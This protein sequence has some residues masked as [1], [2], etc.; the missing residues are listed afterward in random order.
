MNNIDATGHVTGRSV[1][2]DDIPERKGTLY[3]LAVGADIAHG[4]IGH[5][6]MT[7]AESHP[8]I[9]SIL[10]SKDI[11]GENQVGGI[12]P[13]E[14]LFAENEVHF[15][16]QP[17]ALIV[18]ENELS[19]RKARK[20]IKIQYNELPPITDPRTA[21]E[22]GLFLVPPRTF[23]SGDVDSAWSDCA[24][25]FEGTAESGSQEHLY[26]ET[27]G[28]Y[29]YPLEN[30]NLKIH[31]STQGPAIVQKT[32]ANVLGRSMHHIEVDVTR[33]GGAF[34]GKEDQATVWACMTA[35][36]AQL[37][38]RPIK[39]SLQRVDDMRMTG[40]R[41]PY[42]SDF[43]I[44]LSEE[45]K[46]LAFEASYFQNGGAAADLSPAIM[47]RTLF[48]VT[49]S[50]YIPN[51]KATAYSCRTNLPPFTAFRGFG[52]PQAMFVMESAIA[53]AA[54]RLKIPALEIQSRNLIAE[55]DSFHYGQVAV[56]PRA[57]ESWEKLHN[58]HKLEKLANDISEFNASNQLFKKG[59]ALMP[60][61]FGISFTKTPMN[62]ARALVHIYQD[63]SAGISTGAVEMGQGV[64]TKLVQVAAKTLS[65][66]PSRVRIESTNTTRVANTSPTAASSGADLNG[67][68]LALACNELMNRLRRVAAKEL[69]IHEEKL[70]IEFEKVLNS[71]KPTVISWD[72]LIEH[73]VLSR[74]NLTAVGHYATPLIHFDKTTG[75]GHPF[76]YHVFGLAAVVAKVD[77]LRGR[78]EIEQVEVVHDFGN[79]LNLKVDLGQLEGGIV[80]GIGWVTMEEVSFDDKGQLLANSLSTYKVPDIYAAPKHINCT[81]LGS[82]GP[83]LAIMKSKAIGEPPFMYGIGAWFALRN[84]I[85]AFNPKSQIPFVSPMTPEQVL[86][87]L[88]PQKK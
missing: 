62:Q 38:Q 67:K 25:I 61:C 59:M 17:I 56:S 24:Y 14:P 35:L 60:V 55:K 30:G 81:P 41:H 76:A 20:L 69:K 22:L 37:L 50:Y 86:L 2:L 11:P 71:G 45:L 70:K 16:G 87:S 49:N 19:A 33:L 80:Q 32:A 15:H 51:V 1:Y 4:E 23:S 13:D 72:K 18:A 65:I 3:A 39:M 42:S 83:D 28:A 63:G 12:V 34:G 9:V 58:D 57:R 82:E 53:L 6:D 40:K 73:A 31:S 54:E 43:K 5:I 52:A 64:N 79:S 48:H 74:V 75:K 84:A 78:Y 29:A 68:A 46:I 21:A 36:A 7:E 27:Q 88:Y 66:D 44:G 85:R 10:T 26:I 47:E 8:G 77:C